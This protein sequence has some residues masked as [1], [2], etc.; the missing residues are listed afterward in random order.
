[1]GHGNPEITRERA[2]I[3]RKWQ[4]GHQR[5]ECF[6]QSTWRIYGIL[7]GCVGSAGL[8]AK[9]FSYNG[10]SNGALLAV[11]AVPKINKLRVINTLNSSTPAASTIILFIFS[12]VYG[13]VF[14]S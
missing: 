2:G 14:I 6:F 3:T 12:I 5:A 7:W 4:V 8:R 11:V 13:H 1:M 9:V 10:S